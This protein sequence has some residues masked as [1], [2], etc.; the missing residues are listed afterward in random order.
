M[1]VLP[2]PGWRSR[3]VGAIAVIASL[4]TIV[5]GASQLASDEKGEPVAPAARE[6]DAT[7]PTGRI[8]FPASGDAISRE[9]TARGTLSGVRD[10]QHVWIVVRDGNL[11]F[12]QS[13]E[14]P[15]SGG[16]WKLEFRHAG[17]TP[18][19]GLELL[20]MGEKGHRFIED[21]LAAREFSGVS[22]IPGAERLDFVE[23][24]RVM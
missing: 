5:V 23:N 6:T 22:K 13:S 20:L 8:I 4:V 18:T 11:V 2:G 14:I 7:E 10:D 21:R 19:I 3:T 16:E 17:R 1:S 15:A 24:L 9:I 12:P